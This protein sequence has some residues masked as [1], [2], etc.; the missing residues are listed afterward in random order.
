MTGV[1]VLER[2]ARNAPLGLRFWDVAGATST[3]YGLRVE[4]FRRANPRVRTLASINAGGVYVT[5][6]L[7]MAP[8]PPGP[9]DFEFS[10]RE[11][12]ELWP[13]TTRAYRVEVSDPDGRF[14]PIAF[15]ADLPARGLFTW[16]APWLS[17]PQPVALPSEVGSPPPLLL[18]RVPLFSAPSRPVP[19]PLAVVYA[20]L[21]ELGSGRDAAWCLLTVAIDGV[22]CGAGLADAQGRIA[23]MFPYPEPPRTSLASPP[24]ARNDF[25]WQLALSAFLHSASPPGPPP[26]VP[27]LADVFDSLSAPRS[28]VESIVSPSL[29]LRLTY[30]EALTA[31]TAGTAGADASLLFV[32]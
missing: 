18:E 28:V 29:P 25:T 1:R 8:P 13:A 5:H 30:R 16:R 17:P 24:E 15:D 12:V 7:P 27:D 22:V 4:V 21:R 26:D 3:V 20:Q 11:P 9:R 23:V 31:R 14:L 6:H 10:D 32:S 2:I 19:E